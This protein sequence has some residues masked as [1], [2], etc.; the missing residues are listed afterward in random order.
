[1]ADTRRKAPRTFGRHT[2]ISDALELGQFL[3]EANNFEGTRR[4]IDVSGDGPNNWGRD[5]TEV[6]DTLVKRGIAINGLPIINDHG[7]VGTPPQLHKNY[8][9][10]VIGGPAAL[11]CVSTGVLCFFPRPPPKL[12]LA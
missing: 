12:L 7:G 11:F 3:I 4:V 2:S 6:R 10:F 9:Y 1:F 5:I 8:F